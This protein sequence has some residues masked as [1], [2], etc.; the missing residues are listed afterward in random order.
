MLSVV[1]SRVVKPDSGSVAFTFVVTNSEL[2]KVVQDCGNDD[3]G[4]FADERMTGVFYF[5]KLHFWV[6]SDELVCVF[7]D[8]NDVIEPLDEESPLHCR[9]E[10]IVVRSFRGSG[11]TKCKFAVPSGGVWPDV[12]TSGG[13]HAGPYCGLEVLCADRGV[14][15]APGSSAVR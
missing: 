9:V 10:P 7:G 11:L 6:E 4:L 3:G 1:T 2:R 12:G 8:G 13:Q 14:V 5:D 15:A